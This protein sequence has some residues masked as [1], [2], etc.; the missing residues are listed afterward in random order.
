M[1]INNIQDKLVIRN[2]K[3]IEERVKYYNE[4]EEERQKVLKELWDH[5][6]ID[7]FKEN[8]QNIIK[9]KFV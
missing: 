9:E 6:Q 4:H 3:D 5:F 8:W 1:N 7:E 2:H